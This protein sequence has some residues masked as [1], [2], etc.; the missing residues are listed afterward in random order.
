MFIFFLSY[1]YYKTCFQL[2]LKLIQ[3]IPSFV[4]QAQHPLMFSC[5]ILD[6]SVS[7]LVVVALSLRLHML[8]SSDF[9]AFHVWAFSYCFSYFCLQFLF[10]FQFIFLLPIPLLYRNLLL[11]LFFFLFICVCLFLLLFRFLGFLFLCRLLRFACLTLWGYIWRVFWV[12]PFPCPFQNSFH[13]L[14]LPP[15]VA[16]NSFYV[17]VCCEKWA[18]ITKKNYSQKKRFTICV[19]AEKQPRQIKRIS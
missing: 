18:K 9:C 1:V 19:Y 13:F 5:P 11:S 4:F 2:G 17:V 12:V 10:S 3:L 14:P 8:L 16:C 7:F 15:E 6:V